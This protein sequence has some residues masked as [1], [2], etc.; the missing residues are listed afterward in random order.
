M[1]ESILNPEYR[2]KQIR[3]YKKKRYAP[4]YGLEIIHLLLK[5]DGYKLVSFC[6]NSIPTPG[7]DTVK[8]EEANP[9]H[10]FEIEKVIVHKD[11]SVTIKVKNKGFVKFLN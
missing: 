4:V 10:N 2:R 9:V 11:L 7:S 5:K 8:I 1:K 3:N 6:P